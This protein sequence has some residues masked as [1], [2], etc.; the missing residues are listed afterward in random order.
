MGQE[1]KNSH[2]SILNGSQTF[3]VVFGCSDLAEEIEVMSEKLKEIE[4]NL[5]KVDNQLAKVTDRIR[6]IESNIESFQA[7]VDFSHGRF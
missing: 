2:S 1:D 7:F 3:S 6:N 5:L 4:A